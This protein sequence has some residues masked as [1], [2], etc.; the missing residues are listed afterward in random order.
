[1]GKQISE[2]EVTKLLA[3]AG[4]GIINISEGLIAPSDEEGN[5]KG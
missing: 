1:M 2:G 5:S 3:K 4:D